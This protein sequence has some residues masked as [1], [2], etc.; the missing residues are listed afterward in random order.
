[1]S[2]TVGP[3]VYDTSF[4]VFPQD[5]NYNVPPCIFGGKMLAEMDNA[6]A[7]VSRR[8]LYG[9]LCTDAVTVSV[10]VEFLRPAYLGEIVVINAVLVAVGT[11]SLD[12]HVN[13]YREDRSSGENQKMAQGTFRFV[14]R[15]NGN[16]I[17]HNLKFGA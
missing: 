3:I 4:T 8:A 13:C 1:M 17:A 6:A 15:Q 5:T 16:P 11:K 10:N 2:I 14:S 12:I 7:M 9:T